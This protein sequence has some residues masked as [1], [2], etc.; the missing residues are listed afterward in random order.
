M[1]EGADVFSVEGGTL[2]EQLHA[3]ADTVES[4]GYA[5]LHGAHTTITD[6]DTWCITVT[7]A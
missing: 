7:V 3:I 1:N 5:V 4:A 6:D 2:S